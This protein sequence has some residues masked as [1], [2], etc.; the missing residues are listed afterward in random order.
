MAFID[1]K[2]TLQ[3]FIE[4]SREHLQGIENDLLAIEAAG[5]NIDTDLVNK[6][7]RAVHSIKGGA[8]FLGLDTIK[9]LAHWMENILSM[10]RNRELVPT[11]P[12]V[13][14]LLSSAD[15][16]TSMVNNAETSNE[17]DIVEQVVALKGVT[18]TSLPEQSQPTVENL[19]HISL[20]DGK[21]LFTLSEFEIVQ[22]QK[23]GNYLYLVE[24][25]LIEDIERKGK[26]PLNIIKDF[27][28]TGLL[29]A[30][31]VDVEAVGTLAEGT[32]TESLPFF[33][34]YATIMEPD[35]VRSMLDIDPSRIQYGGE[36][37]F[38]GASDNHQ[39]DDLA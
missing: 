8:G 12:I 22:A 20:P 31:K 1:D 15:V 28:K 26:T 24:Y 14:I 23:G 17:V 3:V 5:A 39:C 4:D 33:V 29:L 27:Q 25:D 11:S 2:E 34:L 6:V 7:F 21:M 32:D 19:V 10:V 38:Y 36:F 35:I 30:S 16:L 18:T 37:T 9:E 13:S